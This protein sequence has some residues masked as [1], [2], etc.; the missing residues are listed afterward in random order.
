MGIIRTLSGVL[1]YPF[2]TADALDA[3]QQ[4]QG[5]ELRYEPR[6][7]QTY[8]NLWRPEVPTLASRIWR[9]A[10]SLPSVNSATAFKELMNY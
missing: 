4:R 9:R 6:P 5:C 2:Q 8:A 1:S 7:G 3:G 10:C